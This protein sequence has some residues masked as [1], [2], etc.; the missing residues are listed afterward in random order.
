MKNLILNIA[1]LYLLSSLWG[2]GKWADYLLNHTS[3]Y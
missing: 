3:K 1:T 2:G